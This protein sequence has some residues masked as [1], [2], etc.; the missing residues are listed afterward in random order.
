M[1]LTKASNPALSFT[2]RSTHTFA[3]KKNLM[4]Q[5]CIRKEPSDLDAFMKEVKDKFNSVYKTLHEHGK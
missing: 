5:S 3:S 2:N 4:S 1:V